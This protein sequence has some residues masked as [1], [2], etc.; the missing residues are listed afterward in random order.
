[1]AKTLLRKCRG[2]M[3]FHIVT[4]AFYLLWLKML[5]FEGWES[6]IP[7]VDKFLSEFIS[8]HRKAYS[9]NCVILRLIE[10]WKI[11][12]D[13]ENFVGAVLMD[14]SKAFECIPHDLL[15]AKL[16][17]YGFSE[18]SLVFFYSCL[19]HF[20]T[21][22]WSDASKMSSSI[23]HTASLKNYFLECHNVPY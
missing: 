13:N 1:M 17:A 11:A 23:T 21:P 2:K 12:L 3:H 16:H 7:F 22:I 19:K 6:I 8:V 9:T 15:N 20:S 14:L 18:N 4:L 5:K 10:P